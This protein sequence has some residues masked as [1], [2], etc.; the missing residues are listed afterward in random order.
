MYKVSSNNKWF[1]SENDWTDKFDRTIAVWPGTILK[2]EEYQ[3]FKDFIK[4]ESGADVEV[5]GSMRDPE[6]SEIVVFTVYGEIGN[7][8]VWRFQLG[9]RWWYDMFWST[10]G[11]RIFSDE[12]ILPIIE[13]LGLKIEIKETEYE[14]IEEDC[15]A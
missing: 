15:D 10:N 12:E 7:F 13:K 11:G 6:G 1:S 3:A 4:S 8:S 14:L 9:M 5:I 2:P